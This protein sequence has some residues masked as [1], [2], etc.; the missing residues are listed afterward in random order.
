V[1]VTSTNLELNTTI[2]EL[3]LLNEKDTC[4]TLH[5]D[6]TCSAAFSAGDCVVPL[7]LETFGKDFVKEQLTKVGMSENGKKQV[8]FSLM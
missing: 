7:R 6:G 2:Q 1:L 4:C 5:P 8:S 3:L